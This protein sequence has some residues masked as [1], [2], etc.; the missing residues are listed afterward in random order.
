[1]RRRRAGPRLTFVR[2]R[3][4][5]LLRGIARES[6]CRAGTLEPV[7]NTPEAIVYDVV[8][9][10]CGK[11]FREELLTGAAGRYYG[12]KCP[13]CKLFVPFERVAEQDDIPPA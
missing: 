4:A 11:S 8:C 10:H 2:R 1:V 9:P 12:F 6:D 5:G 7:A 3:N 13:H